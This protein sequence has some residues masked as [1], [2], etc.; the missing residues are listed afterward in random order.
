M[1]L[2]S[3]MCFIKLP[4]S[5]MKYR[6]VAVA[7][8]WENFANKYEMCGQIC[9]TVRC[10]E[11]R[12]SEKAADKIA[13]CRPRDRIQL[14]VPRGRGRFAP[15]RRWRYQFNI[16]LHAPCLCRIIDHELCPWETL[17]SKLKQRIKYHGMKNTKLNDK[18]R[19]AFYCSI[20]DFLLFKKNT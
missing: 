2:N 3:P 19:N 20:T 12:I 9:R 11:S 16:Q 6:I 18:F 14:S 7:Y 5:H 17:K 1:D 4:N 10:A 13:L 8:R 15:E